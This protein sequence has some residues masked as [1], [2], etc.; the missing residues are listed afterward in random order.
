MQDL[1]AP[2]GNTRDV[3][4][5]DA[6][7]IKSFDTILPSYSE[8]ITAFTPPAYSESSTSTS[9]ASISTNIRPSPQCITPPRPGTTRL[10]RVPDP[11]ILSI[12][13]SNLPLRFNGPS[14][15]WSP[16]IVY[17]SSSRKRGTG[18]EPNVFFKNL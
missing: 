14:H 2:N 6:V 5:D 18:P 16:R 15:P 3:F 4:A 10:S 17:P 7:S 9:S 11:Q 13:Q 1:F 8:A 12:S